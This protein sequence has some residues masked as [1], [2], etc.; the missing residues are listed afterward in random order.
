MIVVSDA[1]PLTNLIQIQKLSILKDIFG[2]VVI[3]S[4]VYKELCVIPEQQKILAEQ[5]WI[6]VKES[7]DKQMVH[8]LEKNLD[9]GGGKSQRDLDYE[10]LDCWEFF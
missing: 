3:T 8:H 5:N 4:S 2:N 9:K 6:H 7:A 10:L 1:S